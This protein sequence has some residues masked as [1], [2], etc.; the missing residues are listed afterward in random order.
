MRSFARPPRSF[1]DMPRLRSAWVLVLL[2]GAACGSRTPGGNSATAATPPDAGP[3]AEIAVADAAPATPDA[4]TASGHAIAVLA[5]AGLA[6]IGIAP[7]EVVVA[8][9]LSCPGVAEESKQQMAAAAGQ[10]RE[11]AQKSVEAREKLAA[12]CLEIA[13]MTEEMLLKIGC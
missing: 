5:D 13:R 1:R 2:A 6:E 10:W 9:F 8:R 4:G 12:A 7:C 3:V 11:E